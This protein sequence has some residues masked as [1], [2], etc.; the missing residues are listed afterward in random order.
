MYKS[1]A[2]RFTFFLLLA[3]LMGCSTTKNTFVNRTFHDLSA[4]YNGLFNARLKLEE[5]EQKLAN[6]H[7]DKYDRVLSVF[8][9]GDQAKA[10][11]VFPLLDD[12]IKRVSTVITRHT[13]V[14]KNGNEIPSAEKWIDD[15]WLVYGKCQFFKHEYFDA[16]ETFKYIESTYKK[17]PTRFAASLWLAKTYLELTQLRD[18]EDRL[19]YLRNQKDMPKKVRAEYY[20]VAADFFLQTK[21]VQKGIDNLTKAAAQADKR[22]DRIRYTFILAQ[23]HQK[24][25]NFTKAFTLYTQVIKKNPPYEMDFNARINRARCYDADSKGGETVKKE[26]LKMRKDPKNK[27]YMDQVYYALAGIAQKENNED[28][29]I[30]YLNKSVAAST[31]NVNQKA[32]SYLD[33][34]KIFFAKPDYKKAQAYYDSTITYLS[35]DYP[36]Y[37]EILSKRNSLTKLVKY[38]RTIQLEDSLQQLAKLSPSDREKVIDDKLKKEKEE[39][40]KEEKEK[41][42]QQFNQIFDQGNQQQTNQLN[43]QS[44][45][46]W[47]FYNPQALGFGLNDFTKKWGNRKLEDNWRRS[48]KELQLQTNEEQSETKDSL[49]TETKELKS[50]KEEQKDTK[51]NFLK[52]IPSTPEALDKSTTKIIDAYYNAAL[53]YKDQLYDQREAALMLEELLEKYP[54]N[55][56]ALQSNYQLYRLYQALNETQR[57]DYYRNIILTEYATSDYAEIIRNPNYALDLMNKKSNLE[58]FYEETYRKYLNGE[59][60]SVIQRKGESD[61]LYPQ[62]ILLPKFDYL[63]TLSI[64]KTQS[65]KTFELSLQDIVRNYASD[66]VKEQAELILAY[67][68]GSA[69]EAPG[70]QPPL[71]DTTARLYVYN[72]D[73]AQF[74]VVSFQNIGGP[75]NS[76]SLTLKISNYNDKYYGLK[77]YR[78]S[79]LLYDHRSKIIVVKEFLNKDEA[80][81]YYNGMNDNDEVYGNLNPEAYQQFIISTNNFDSFIRERKLNDYLDFFRQ[82]Y[83]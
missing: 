82:F 23:L 31:T 30:D 39:K 54:K 34:A 36:T 10:K 38:L 60:A 11:M 1:I 49:V 16:I 6:S 33:L 76:D 77:G 44:G 62:S 64:G 28:E 24:Q 5:A 43:Q 21:N 65:L 14:T 59:Y 50:P 8:K 83:K 19:D 61:I 69:G 81:E 68:H 35:N 58:I 63:K 12:A 3:V 48:G 52:A 41:E 18:A 22:Y 7:E 78:I 72:P 73:T 57:A 9:Y 71:V 79:N 56:Y 47:Y 66:P 53:L 67:I 37:S 2:A 46:R 17:E 40:E 70:E 74:V 51:E 25:N 20:A 29:A 27:E 45:A 15:N 80:L 32:L 26:L 13:I 75:I 42:E 55:K 4:H